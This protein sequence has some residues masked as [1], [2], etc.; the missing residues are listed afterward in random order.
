MRE[1]RDPQVHLP[2]Q[3]HGHGSAVLSRRFLWLRRTALTGCGTTSIQLNPAWKPKVMAFFH[4]LYRSGITKVTPTLAPDGF[5]GEQG[6][7]SGQ[8][9]PPEL[10]DPNTNLL[11]CGY[12]SSTTLVDYW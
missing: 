5:G 7:L 8:P 10:V 3:L 9:L 12:D 1:Q 2:V 4:D 11:P 6:V